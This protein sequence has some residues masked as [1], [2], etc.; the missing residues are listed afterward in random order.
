MASYPKDF[1]LWD[2]FAADVSGLLAEGVAILR[3]RRE[4][5]RDMAAHAYVQEIGG[6]QV[7][8]LNVPYMFASDCGEELLKLYPNAPFV[9]AWFRRGDGKLQ[10][11][12]RSE[13][14]RTDVSEIA[15]RFGGGGHRNASG[16]Q[17]DEGAD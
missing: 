9:A 16:F 14:H 4:L 6:H 5:V 15:A 13:D 2:G 12:L 3:A 11:S 10:F 17:V 1:A 8:T 7:P